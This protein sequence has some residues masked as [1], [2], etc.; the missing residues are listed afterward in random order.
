MVLASFIESVRVNVTEL[1]TSIFELR[2]R[3]DKAN[4]IYFELYRLRGQIL[5]QLLRG[6]R[7]F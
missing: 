5:T 2:Q 7:L 4:T 6:T 1:N 3:K